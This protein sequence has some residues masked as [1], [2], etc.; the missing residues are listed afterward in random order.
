MSGSL[1][2]WMLPYLPPKLVT[3]GKEFCK[4]HVLV[5][6]LWLHINM[7]VTIHVVGHCGFTLTLILLIMLLVTSV[8]SD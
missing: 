3:F 2:C 1:F 4:D 7:V 6:L 8:G 5:W